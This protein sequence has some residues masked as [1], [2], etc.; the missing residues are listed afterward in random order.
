MLS[1][2]RPPP[3]P[4]KT[5]PEGVLPKKCREGGLDF[6]NL[7]PVLNPEYESGAIA[8]N[9]DNF[10]PWHVAVDDTTFHAEITIPVKVFF[11]QK[12]ADVAAENPD[13]SVGVACKASGGHLY[14]AVQHGSGDFL[15]A[16][17]DVLVKA[18][19]L[20]DLP[21]HQ[22]AYDHWKTRAKAY[23]RGVGDARFAA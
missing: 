18:E 12:I 17:A 4:P 19:K 2:G 16:I 14:T 15:F 10:M 20:Q 3:H 11:E 13:I 9:I 7:Y 23:R 1:F 6:S 8:G 21:E 22:K 5:T